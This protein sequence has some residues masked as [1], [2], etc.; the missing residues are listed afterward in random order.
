MSNESFIQWLA[1]G[2]R[3]LSSNAIATKLSGID[4]MLYEPRGWETLLYPSDHD[5]FKRC[6]K[7]LD[8]VPEFRERLYEMKDVSEVWSRL[9]D[10]WDEFEKLYC[11]LP[12]TKVG[13]L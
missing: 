3:G 1:N 5:D 7:L 2:E 8:Q 13:G 10:N 9:V 12:P 6:M 4:C 11:Q